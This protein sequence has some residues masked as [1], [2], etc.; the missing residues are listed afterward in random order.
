MH[1][2]EPDADAQCEQSLPRGADELAARFLNLRRKRT[3]GRLQVV[4]TFGDDTVLMA[5]SPVLSDLVSAPNAP[6][7]SGR[8]GRGRRSKFYETSDNIVGIIRGLAQCSWTSRIKLSAGR[9][10]RLLRGGKGLLV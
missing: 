6:T 2:P 1:D 7:G 3:L 5:V 10:R 8:G 4:T 9:E